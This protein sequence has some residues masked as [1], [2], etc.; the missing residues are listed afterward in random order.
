LKIGTTSTIPV[1]ING[2]TSNTYSVTF[3]IMFDVS[4]AEMVLYDR[5]YGIDYIELVPVP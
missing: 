4:I 2:S 3:R 5:I 1:F